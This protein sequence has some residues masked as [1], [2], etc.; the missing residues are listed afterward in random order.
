MAIKNTASDDVTNDDNDEDD[1]DDDG[2]TMN[3]PKNSERIC[4]LGT[5]K[6]A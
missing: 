4:D 3:L 1:D 5:Q 6:S 2:T